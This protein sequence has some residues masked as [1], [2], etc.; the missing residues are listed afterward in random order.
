MLPRPC[1][2]ALRLALKLSQVR[3]SHAYQTVTRRE[4]TPILGSLEFATRVPWAVVLACSLAM[5]ELF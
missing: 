4:D 2:G 3:I 1:C 5:L